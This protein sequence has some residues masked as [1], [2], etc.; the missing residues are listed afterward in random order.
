[1]DVILGMDGQCGL[2]PGGGKMPRAHR[3]WQYGWGRETACVGKHGFWVGVG[4][5]MGV[6]IRRWKF[7]SA[8]VR[9]LYS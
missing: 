6:F 4:K 2:I 3:A 1:M 7:R 8:R 9:E 5:T